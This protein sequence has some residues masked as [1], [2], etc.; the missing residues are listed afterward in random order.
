MEE[1]V[2]KICLIG[3]SELK[4]TLSRGIAENKFNTNYMP[5][6]GVDIKTKQIIVD[7]Q[8][9][10]LILMDTAYQELFGDN[11]RKSYYEGASAY[12]I[13]FEKHNDNSFA[14]VPDFIEDVREV[15]MDIPIVLVGIITEAPEKVPYA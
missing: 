15:S 1:W 8:R 9:I 6:L 2:L 14:A 5:S 13:F 11:L 10:K 12:I 3:S 7:N 4:T